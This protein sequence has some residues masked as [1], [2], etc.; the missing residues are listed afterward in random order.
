MAVHPLAE[1][2]SRLLGMKAEDLGIAPTEGLPSVW[3]V[4]RETGYDTGP[5]TLF[6]LAEGTTSLYLP[7]GG[8]IIGAGEHVPVRA[9]GHAL[10]RTAEFALS[11]CARQVEDTPPRAGE[12]SFLV[13]TRS[14]VLAAR[15]SEQELGEGVGPLSALYFAAEALLSQVRIASENMKND[16]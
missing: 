15:A 11:Q 4:M 10:L 13:L 12:V 7:N 6:T 5:L 9:A 2:R 1:M 14:G 8:G 3:G 16:A